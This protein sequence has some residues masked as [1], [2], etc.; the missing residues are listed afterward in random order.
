M[1]ALAVLFGTTAAALAQRGDFGAD[2][3]ISVV[4]TVIPNNT[5]PILHEAADAV[6]RAAEGAM[7]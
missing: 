7:P 6:T 1:F 5:N 3:P 2:S 4:S